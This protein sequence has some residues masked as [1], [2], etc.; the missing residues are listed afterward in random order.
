VLFTSIRTDVESKSIPFIFYAG[1]SERRFAALKQIPNAHV[2]KVN[3]G[4]EIETADVLRVATDK[5][6]FAMPTIVKRLS[7]LQAKGVNGVFQIVAADVRTEVGKQAEVPVYVSRG[8]PK[9]S[10]HLQEN[11]ESMAHIQGDNI[12][13]YRV[14]AGSVAQR[15]G[16]EDVV[17]EYQR[18]DFTLDKGEISRLATEKGNVRYL[19]EFER[20]YTSILYAE[21]RFTPP[22]IFDLS[23]GIS[24]PVL[25]RLKAVRAINNLILADLAYSDQFE[26]VRSALCHVAVGFSKRILDEIDPEASRAIISWSWLNEVTQAVLQK[27]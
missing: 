12:P 27:E 24:L 16:Q 13:H 6:Q 19:T 10:A 8:K 15:Y 21:H 20:F 9:K 18:F 11:L 23:G 2:E 1:Q 14:A 3:G 22:T 17:G 4:E 7:D 25:I 5:L 26:L